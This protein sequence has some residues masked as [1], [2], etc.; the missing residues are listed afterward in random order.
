MPVSTSWAGDGL[1]FLVGHPRSGT[2]FLGRLLGAHPEVAYW[3][4]PELL[5]SLLRMEDT[6]R[7]LQRHAALDAGLDTIPLT[8]ISTRDQLVL[9][10]VAMQAADAR[11]LG[12]AR[13]VARGLVAQFCLQAAKPILVE[14]TPFQ[15]LD[16]ADLARFLPEAKVIHIIRDPR[17]VAAS[18]LRWIE[19]AGWPPW[20]AEADDPVAAVAGQ[21]NDYVTAGLVAA[22]GPVANFTLLHE[23]LLFD[24]AAT[25]GQLMEFLDV[26]WSPRLDAFLA[27][28]FERGIDSSTSGGWRDQLS[29]EQAALVD[30]LCGE[31]MMRLGYLDGRRA[32]RLVGRAVLGW[33]R[34]V[35]EED[36]VV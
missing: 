9:D 12:Q 35:R 31:L 23:Q 28:G 3:E 20:L 18:T 2:T 4:E 6:L 1:V 10:D 19:A 32:S 36:E 25:V 15:V 11:S 33:L 30:E 7:R 26:E 16:V 22:E 29:D 21:W 5:R 24:T 14:K 34:R 8:V 17:D 27:D 13:G